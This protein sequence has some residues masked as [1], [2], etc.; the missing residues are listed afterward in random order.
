MDLGP[1]AFF[2]VTAYVAAGGIV[3]I[4]IGWI[5]V[6]HRALKR[7]LADFDARGITR[8]SAEQKSAA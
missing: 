3:A 7:T 5:A 6:E 2:I 1:H 4:L 8:R